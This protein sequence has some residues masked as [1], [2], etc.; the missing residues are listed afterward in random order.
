MVGPEAA[1][2]ETPPM[3][4]QIELHAKNSR[5]TKSF[6]RAVVIQEGLWIVVFVFERDKFSCNIKGVNEVNELECCVFH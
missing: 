2:S 6:T 3:N 5:L 4:A 1:L